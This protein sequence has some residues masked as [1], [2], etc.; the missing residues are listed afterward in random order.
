M[1]RFKINK[2]FI[3]VLLMSILQFNAFSDSSN[4]ANPVIQTNPVKENPEV[5]LAST[6]LLQVLNDKPDGEAFNS[7]WKFVS[8]NIDGVK[9]WDFQISSCSTEELSQ[10][11]KNFKKLGIKI[12]YEKGR[13]P[14]PPDMHRM[15]VK[16]RSDNI[17]KQYLAEGKNVPRE[18]IEKEEERKLINDLGEMLSDD[19]YQNF[20]EFAQK[21]AAT[22][23]QRILKIKEAGGLDILEFIEFDGAFIKNIFPYAFGISQWGFTE[24]PESNRFKPGFENMEIFTQKVYSRVIELIKDS[25]PEAA[26]LKV[27][28]LP[29]IHFWTYKQEVDVEILPNGDKIYHNVD[30]KRHQ[31]KAMDLHDMLAALNTR[32]DVFSGITTDYPYNL[33]MRPAGGRRYRGFANEA[34]ELGFTFGC[35]INSMSGERSMKEL[36]KDSFEFA[37]LLKEQVEP[38]MYMVQSW[39]K[40]PTNSEIFDSENQEGSFMNLAKK[41]IELVKTN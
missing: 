1:I 20:E 2:L 17:E 35:C 36:N 5:W 28:H 11:I 22:E 15:A 10:W 9:F 27:I 3:T 31:E 25:V 40:H 21:A 24:I 8:E 33:Y 29:N 4:S 18:E 16:K 26:H 12:G 13:W 14:L 39:F 38:D 7:H 23:I 32:R 30:F 6:K 19:K 37:R 34:K 41:I